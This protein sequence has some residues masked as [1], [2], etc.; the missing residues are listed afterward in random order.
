[1]RNVCATSTRQLGVLEST[2]QHACRGQDMVSYTP[3]DFAGS[4][5]DTIEGFADRKSRPALGIFLLTTQCGT[6]ARLLA[7]PWM[8]NWI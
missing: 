8:H 3:I 4:L 5:A 6:P 7:T 2:D 1:M